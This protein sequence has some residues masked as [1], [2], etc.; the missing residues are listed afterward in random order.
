MANDS[1]CPGRHEL[2][3]PPRQRAVVLSLKLSSRHDQVIVI[4]ASSGVSGDPDQWPAKV[5]DRTPPVQ[6]IPRGISGPNSSAVSALRAD[7]LRAA[8]HS[9]QVV[10]PTGE[11]FP[12]SQKLHELALEMTQGLPTKNCPA[13]QPQRTSSS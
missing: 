3:N 6:S 8:P 10:A 2:F 13:L 1:S 9:W 5:P 12:A 7:R 4:A 11:Y